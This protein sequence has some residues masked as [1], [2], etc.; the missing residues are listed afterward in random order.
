[1][2]NALLFI[3]LTASAPWLYAHDIITT[4]ITF[5]KEIVRIVHARC[6]RCHRDGGSA[7]SL[8]TYKDARPWA[9]AI[10]EEVLGRRMPPWGAVKG[11]GEFRNDEGLSSEQVETLLGWIDGGVPEGEASS[12]P[13]TP[14]VVPPTPALPK[15]S[16][17]VTDRGYV[18][19]RA[20]KLDGLVPVAVPAGASMQ[21]T[22][23]LPDGNVEPLVWLNTYQPKYAHAFLFEEPLALPAGTRIE[24]IAVGAKI[25]LLPASK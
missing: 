15:P 7:F 11:F 13:A 22:A 19:T 21:I 1:M 25:G 16:A 20:M 6:A 2:R 17:I 4:S 12:L 9:Q 8:M 5:N 23:V 18:L 10:K 24:G 14:F 3:G